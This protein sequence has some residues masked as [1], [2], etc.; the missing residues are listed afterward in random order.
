MFLNIC[1]R[2]QCHFSVFFTKW[3]LFLNV[4]HLSF[5]AFLSI[6]GTGSGLWGYRVRFPI[7]IVFV[8]GTAL[9]A[10]WQR[11]E[12]HR[13]PRSESHRH[14]RSESH[15]FLGCEGGNIL[16]RLYV[17]EY[18][19]LWFDEEALWGYVETTR[20]YI[21]RPGCEV[22]PAWVKGNKNEL[23]VVCVVL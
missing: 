14:P 21:Y 13:H 18:R 23:F 16:F 19:P 1:A 7:C 2:T 15:R 22:L 10:R 20:C 12:S 3:G 17:N 4:S 5:A 11:S 6:V 8:S 9:L